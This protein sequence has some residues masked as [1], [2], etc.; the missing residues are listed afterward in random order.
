MFNEDNNLLFSSTKQDIT[1]SINDTG[2]DLPPEL[3]EIKE[4]ADAPIAKAPTMEVL[5][6]MNVIPEEFDGNNILDNYDAGIINS[7]PSL[8]QNEIK[9]ENVQFSTNVEPTQEYNNFE[10]EYKPGFLEFPSTTDNYEPH[11]IINTSVQ[12]DVENKPPATLA[13]E[14]FDRVV[15]KIKD[16]GYDIEL[17]KYD[18]EKQIKIEI[19]IKK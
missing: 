19:I 14:V 9:E 5:S 18:N 11:E 7:M 3:G 2:M 16:K 8:E 13:S 17:E 15:S 12:E 4:L 10:L 1:N 6:P